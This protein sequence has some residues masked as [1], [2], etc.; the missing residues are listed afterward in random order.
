MA[1][2]Q[3]PDWARGLLAVGLLLFVVGFWASL[4][5]TA[6]GG[7]MILFVGVSTAGERR[8]S[9]RPPE[10]LLNPGDRPWRKRD[11]R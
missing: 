8:A 1:E 4:W 9:G 2:Q 7:L 3:G 11:D 5:L 6:V 10:T